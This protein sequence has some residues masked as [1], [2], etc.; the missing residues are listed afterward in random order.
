M[1]IAADPAVE[2]IVAT[3]G[4]DITRVEADGV[5]WFVAIG[6]TNVQPSFDVIVNGVIVDTLEAAVEAAAEL[7]PSLAANPAAV[8]LGVTDMTIVAT[9]DNGADLSWSLGRNGP[10]LCLV[11]D[12]I[13]PTAGCSAAGDVVV[14]KPVVTPEQELTFVIVVDAPRCVDAIGV[15]GSIVDSSTS[16]GDGQH[17]YEV[18][19][20]RGT[21]EGWKLRLEV[22]GGVQFVDLP[23]VEG[24]AGFP[25]QLCDG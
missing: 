2:Q 7:E 6:D 10:D 15:E 5:S 8:E 11:T 17:T 3:P 18:F 12:A 14:F 22:A 1:V 24:T 13:E 20:M 19:A 16:A 9:V 25:A 4:Y 23:A 21:S